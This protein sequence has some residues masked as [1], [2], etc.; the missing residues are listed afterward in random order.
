MQHALLVVNPQSRNG[1]SDELNAAIAVL[2]RADISVEVYVSEGTS[3]MVTKISQY[4]QPGGI[5]IIAGGDGTISSALESVYSHNHTL[6]VLPLGTA[7]DLARSLGMP[8][9]LLEAAE[10][11]VAGQ[12]ERINLARV[13]NQYFVNV[14][15]LGLGVDV[16]H[17]L[18]P[19][20]KKYFGVFAYLGAFFRAMKRNRSFKV[21]IHADD[22][23]GSFRAI[24]L[25]VGNGRYYGGGNIVDE[26]A[27]LTDGQLKLFCITPQ[28][29]WKLLLL[30][31]N[32]RSGDL[33][34]ADTVFCKLA[35]KIRITTTKPIK[36]AADGEFKTQTPAEFEVIPKAIEAIVGQMPTPVANEE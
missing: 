17:E 5:V 15:H 6:A 3:Q 1:Q 36:L 13:N 30:G 18:T 21:D 8:Q 4:R 31:R 10:T 26:N 9:T 22:F 2:R 28:P 16:T 32:L 19:E 23:A 35:T 11:I 27:T 7:N 25:A 34:T 14:A 29:A 24:H 20:T 12:R 33:K